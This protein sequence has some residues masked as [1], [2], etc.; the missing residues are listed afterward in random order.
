MFALTMMKVSVKD[1]PGKLSSQMSGVAGII[2]CRLLQNLITIGE[3]QNLGQPQTILMDIEVLW[4]M[5][6][7]FHLACLMKIKLSG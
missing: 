1:K 6:V 3:I 2:A 5:K 4:E 7:K